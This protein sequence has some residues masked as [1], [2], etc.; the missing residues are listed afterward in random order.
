MKLLF[1]ALRSGSAA[2]ELNPGSI[3]SPPCQPSSRRVECNYCPVMRALSVG[4]MIYWK[5]SRIDWTIKGR[6]GSASGPDF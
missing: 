3:I 1:D 2:A 6:V 4:I 5:H